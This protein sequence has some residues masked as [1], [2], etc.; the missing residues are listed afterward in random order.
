MRKQ[1]LL[2]LHDVLEPPLSQQYSELFAMQH[3]QEKAVLAASQH[4]QKTR[5]QSEKKKM[6]LEPSCSCTARPQCSHCMVGPE[7]VRWLD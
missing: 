4:Q 1:Q 3:L 5:I 2:E 7:D 6:H